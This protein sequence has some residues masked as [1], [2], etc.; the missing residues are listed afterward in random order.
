MLGNCHQVTCQAL[1]K[2][3]LRPVRLVM[4]GLDPADE[5]V[6]W[7]IIL[8]TWKASPELSEATESSTAEIS[9]MQ[10]IQQMLQHKTQDRLSD[11]D[12]D[13]KRRFMHALATAA[14]CQTPRVRTPVAAPHSATHLLCELGWQT[15][16]LQALQSF[17]LSRGSSTLLYLEASRCNS[18]TLE[19]MGDSNVCVILLVCSGV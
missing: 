9:Q 16:N 13:P 10:G 1:F 15:P 8:E 2:A 12:T 14:L 3:E 11:S 5:L 18:R 4:C 7:P 17:I 6:L 19:L